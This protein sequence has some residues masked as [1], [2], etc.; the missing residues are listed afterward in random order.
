MGEIYIQREFIFWDP[1]L[2]LLLKC[3]LLKLAVGFTILIPSS[4][5]PLYPSLLSFGIDGFA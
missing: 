1:I 2:F 4:L 5:H 3:F